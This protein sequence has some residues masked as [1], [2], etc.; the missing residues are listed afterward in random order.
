VGCGE[1]KIVIDAEQTMDTVF[2]K[3]IAG[4]HFIRGGSLLDRLQQQPDKF[5]EL[6]KLAASGLPAHFEIVKLTKESDSTGKSSSNEAAEPTKVNPKVILDSKT[7]AGV[8]RDVTYNISMTLTSLSSPLAPVQLDS[9]LIGSLDADYVLTSVPF[10]DYLQTSNT[11]A[12][13]GILP[14]MGSGDM[15]FSPRGLFALYDGKSG[16]KVWEGQIGT[17]S[18]N[19]TPTPPKGRISD[20]SHVIL[21]AAYLLTGDIETPLA[22]ILA[23]SAVQN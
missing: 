5:N 20:I 2:S 7:I 6:C 8:K 3:D 12:L 17:I 14:Y 23:L 16:Q 21:G 19:L 11:A 13:F 1:M 9:T 15:F 10:S 4:I 22:R 18:T